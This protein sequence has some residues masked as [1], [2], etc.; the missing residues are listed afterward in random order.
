MFTIVK[1]YKNRLVDAH[2]KKYE[3]WSSAFYVDGC[4]SVSIKMY[5]SSSAITHFFHAFDN[6]NYEKERQRYPFRWP[7]T[8][9]RKKSTFRS[10][11]KG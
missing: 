4:V 10:K 9:N 5:E 7:P 2:R 3:I 8:Q 11:H 1:N 6:N